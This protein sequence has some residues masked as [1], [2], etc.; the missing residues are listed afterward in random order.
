MVQTRIAFVL[1]L[2]FPALSLAGAEPAPPPKPVTDAPTTVVADRDSLTSLELDELITAG[3]RESD[4]AMCAPVSDSHFLRRASLDLVGRQ[5]TPEELEAFLADGS[6]DKRSRVVERMLASDEFG[7]N[8]A[9]Y[10][11]DTISFHV[12]PPEL[13]FLNYEPFEKWLA[14][15]LNEN[16]SWD[17]I[18]TEILT[19]T[20]KVAD[21]P[22]ATFVAYHQG[23]SVQLAAETT[24]IFLGLQIQCAQCHDHP[25][26]DW[27]R[28]QFHELAAFFARSRV[29][30]P[31]NEGAETVVSDKGKGEY[32]MPDAMDPRKKGTEVVPAFLSIQKIEKGLS[33]LERRRALAR[34]VV[35]PEN[36]WFSKAYVNRIWARLM[37]RGFYEPVDNIGQYQPQ[38]MPEVHAALTESF[39][40]S[41]YDVK[42]FFRLVMNTQAYQRGLP[43]DS[44]SPESPFAAA[45]PTQLR[46]DEV[47]Q[48]LVT[49]IGL[50]NVT[51]PPMKATAEVRF[52]PPPKS[53]REIVSE[54]FGYDP[55]L[56]PE[57]VSRTLSQAMLLM[58][59]EQ[60]Q[61]QIN[62]DPE[63]GTDLSE[64]LRDEADNRAAV[65]RLFLMVLARTP[66]EREMTIAL[67]HIASLDDRGTAFEDLLW[68]L[69]NSTEFTTKR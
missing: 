63:S 32:V 60:L 29:K 14:E 6:A 55:S 50:P 33:D 4:A 38:L 62:A 23:D 28:E 25:F 58:N 44:G 19:G 51:P 2:A 64:L 16:T 5:P 31:W 26:D 40:D 65:E 37:G 12:Q 61:A 36:E 30:M 46:G 34:F 39:R 42:A 7:R 17:R 3:L 24:R 66:S 13:T 10:W 9:A 27:Q 22:A 41:G 67:E 48:S 53:T 57:A 69:I 18:V 68:S 11:S 1:V 15:R 49:A 47:F 43:Q 54:T 20:G 45:R 8:W 35:A 52:P 59:N 21:N 56:R